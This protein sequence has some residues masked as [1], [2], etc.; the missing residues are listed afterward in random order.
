MRKVIISAATTSLLA[1]ASYAQTGRENPT[2][3]YALIN[4]SVHTMDD[5]GTV[6]EAIGIEDGEIVYVGNAGGLKEVIGIGTKVI[7]LDGA[8]VIPGFVEGHIHVFA[9][10]LIMNGVDLQSDDSDE[11]FER[12][13]AYTA[14]TDDEVVMGYGV[15]FTP[16]SDGNP[17]AAMLDEI[18]SERPM[19]LWAIDGHKAWVNSKALEM[20]GIDKDTPDTVPGYSY[21]ERD[22][23][24]NPTG[25]IVE[26]PAQMQVLS[27]VINI[28][29]DYMVEGVKEWIPRFAASGITTMQDLGFQGIGQDE[30]FRLVEEL[31][32]DGSMPFRV[33]GVYYWNDGNVDP[34][35][36]IQALTAEFTYE[37]AKP[38]KIK[39][40]VDGGDDS[41]SALYVDGYA[42][43]PNTNPDPII[44]RDVIIDAVVRADALGI[45][46]VCHC[47]GDGAVRIMLDAVEAAIQT[48]P[49]RDRRF[50]VAHG[51]SV[52][53]DD[54]PRFG[55]LG[56][57]WNSSGAWMSY[58][59]NLQLVSDVK[60]GT[61]RVQEMFPMKQIAETG[62]KVV[63]GADWPVSGWI[64]EYRPLVA[65]ETAVTRTIDG[66]KDVPPLGGEDAGVSVDTALRASTIYPALELRMEDL[67]GSLEVGKRA[68]LVVLAENLYDIDP[69]DISEVEV[70]YTIMDGKVTWDHT[71][72]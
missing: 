64:S 16:W 61:E 45:D 19:F 70:L 31:V 15:R 13:R 20:A 67:I 29:P 28:T 40:N 69:N 33:R 12:L 37:N 38:L 8:M 21:F 63:L 39:I 47:F 68:D 49:E 4:G 44:P 23:D 62:G 56:V 52:H 48:N 9:G 26:I 25:W 5:A 24:G 53:P 18:E 1:T 22:G 10:G 59:P 58:D 14:E 3:D 11:I 35:A 72:Q 42:D 65:I 46:S 66:R 51:N 41:D 54:I 43:N 57:F 17:T 6:V 55:E 32:K 2:A 60:L 50:A 7:D 71:K 36:E 34:V 27:G 30:G